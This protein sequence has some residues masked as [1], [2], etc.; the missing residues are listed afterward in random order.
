MAFPAVLAIQFR[1]RA[2]NE[3]TEFVLPC[4]PEAI[5]SALDAS[6][7]DETLAGLR[8]NDTDT[9]LQKRFDVAK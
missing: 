4:V 3:V 2:H 6:G 9:L 8:K 1:C 7:N 5:I